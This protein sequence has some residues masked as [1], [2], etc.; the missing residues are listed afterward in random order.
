MALGFDRD[1]DVVNVDDTAEIYA[2]IFDKDDSPV[3]AND[4]L[5][6][7]FTIQRPDSTSVT[8][9]GEVQTDGI[10]FLRY[11]TT[12]IVGKYPVVATFT[13]VSGEVRSVR[14]D[15]E[16]IDPFNPP[17]PSITEIITGATWD[18]LEDCFDSEYGGPWLRDV[19]MDR[20]NR[21]KIP[22]F[23]GEALMD[24]NLVNPPTNAT[25]DQFVIEVPAGS[26]TFPELPLL[27]EGTLLAC[28]RHLMRSY[29]EQP[30][31]SGAQIVY[32][33]RRDYLQRWGTI[34]QIEL[35]TYQR[36]LALWKRQFLGLGH[37]KVLVS[38]KAGRLLPAP[39]RARNIGR[40]YY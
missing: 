32:E 10:G 16:V 3:S 13:F 6:V 14:A 30:L 15:F 36:W 39:L 9:T 33:D 1:Y 5:G 38:S 21:Q 29:V 12:D 31:P 17:A 20:F 22:Q 35:Q 2:R 18:K 19:T 26:G 34:Y 28:I 37:A 11:P 25:A 4:L 23:I 27:A 40:G 7:E 8:Q 24:I